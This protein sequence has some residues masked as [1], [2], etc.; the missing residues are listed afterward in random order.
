M[1]AHGT[2]RKYNE[3]CR[4]LLC[5]NEMQRKHID[6]RAYNQQQGMCCDC[7]RP[8]DADRRMAKLKYCDSCTKRKNGIGK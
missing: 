5:S 1:A 4:C 8:L 7:G 2:M 6:Y 3:G